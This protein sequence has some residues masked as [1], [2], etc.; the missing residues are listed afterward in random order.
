MKAKN[1]KMKVC[2]EKLSHFNCTHCDKWWTVGDA[3]AK[4]KKWFC[5][6]C[7]KEQK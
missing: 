7:G 2:V 5:P 4:N 6:W 3:P 1:Q